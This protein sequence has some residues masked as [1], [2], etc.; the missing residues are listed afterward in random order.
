MRK[1]LAATLGVFLL[2][3]AVSAA[4]PTV[5][6]TVDY[7][8][9]TYKSCVPIV[10]ETRRREY[11]RKWIYK[12]V[13]VAVE[14]NR[15]TMTESLM[16]VQFFHGSDGFFKKVC[17]GAIDNIPNE[18]LAYGIDTRAGTGICPH[19]ADKY[20]NKATVLVPNLST[21]VGVDGKRLVIECHSAKKCIQASK[22]G[23]GVSWK[24]KRKKI[25]ENKAHP[26]NS[27]GLCKN[28]NDKL[29][30]AFSHLIKLLG[31]KKELF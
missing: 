26:R 20:T 7:I 15:L 9:N 10:I 29:H 14:K 5:Q 18:A 27:L 31:G 30:R 25:N 11:S 1:P 3:P 17:Q 21:E 6:E 19:R 4:E 8:N 16:D 23:Q 24:G 13:V 22:T 2:L 28:K 12:A